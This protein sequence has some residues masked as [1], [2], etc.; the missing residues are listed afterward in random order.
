MPKIDKVPI[1]YTPHYN[2]LTEGGSSHFQRPVDAIAE[3]V[4]NSIQACDKEPHRRIHVS[5]FLN[6]SFGNE[7]GFLT[8]SDNG[9]GMTTGTI[10]DFAT[11]ALDKSTRGINDTSST[12]LGRFGVGAK[13]AG[14]YLGNRIRIVTKRKDDDRVMEF[15][16]DK[17]AFRQ[18]YESKSEIYSDDISVRDRGDY[19]L[20]P[21]DERSVRAMQIALTEHEESYD[22]FS[23][24]IIR[25]HKDKVRQL[26]NMERYRDV[27][28]ELAEIY[29]FHLYPEHLPANITKIERFKKA[30]GVVR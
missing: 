14:F 15:T 18:R 27:A 25:M 19:S 9:A 11:Y 22:N 16:F 4:D 30:G 28:N 23:M 6:D 26:L 7:T 13:Q 24:F 17:E 20:V 10:Q 5:F 21:D 12:A 2:T 3:F 1:T 29:H 8:I